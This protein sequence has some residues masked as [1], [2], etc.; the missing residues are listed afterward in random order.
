MSGNIEVP[1]PVNEPVRMYPPGTPERTALKAKLKELSSQE[2]DVPLVIGGEEVRTGKTAKNIMPHNHQHALATCHWGGQEDI[3]A[4][5]EAAVKAQKEWSRWPWEERASVLLKAAELLATTWRDTVNAATMLCQSKTA[6][7]A[8]IDPGVPPAR[9]LRV[10][11]HAVQ[12]HIHS[13]QPADFAGADGQHCAVEAGSH[14]DLHRLLHH[15]AARGCWYAS[16][17]H[18][19]HR[20]RL[21]GNN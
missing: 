11:H 20:W 4:A 17:R 1:I 13:R 9:G 12:L 19:L 5:V 8:E 2:L 3:E 21:G 7:Q 18:Q 16:R 14:H 10:C 6:H 15:E